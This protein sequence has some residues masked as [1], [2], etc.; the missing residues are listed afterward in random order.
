[1][2]ELTFEQVELVSGG[3]SNSSNDDKDNHDDTNRDVNL[4]EQIACLF[5]E[6]STGGVL[7]HV[8]FKTLGMSNTA[9]HAGI[10]GGGMNVVTGWGWCTSLLSS[11]ADYKG[12][13]TAP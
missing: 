6:G 8:F 7:G 2:Q 13:M 5:L 3:S 4:A 11:S 1:M 9:V 10:V 12:M